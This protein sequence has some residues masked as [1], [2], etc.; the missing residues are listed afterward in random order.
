VEL[1]DWILLAPVVAQAI[2]AAL[3]YHRDRSAVMHADSAKQ[4]KRP[5]LIIGIFMLLT[6][7]A[8]GYDFYD[9]RHFSDE[10]R[11]SA[12]LGY[13]YNN[14]SSN[15]YMDVD[16]KQLEQYGDSNK[17][18]LIVRVVYANIDRMTDKVLCKSGVYSIDGQRIKLVAPGTAL[19]SSLQNRRERV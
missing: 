14:P 11:P 5:I 9:R 17:L 4:P 13:G 6:W 1:R 19:R 12:V 7:A 8:V 3:T 10:M 15:Y 16:T 18:V 2:Y